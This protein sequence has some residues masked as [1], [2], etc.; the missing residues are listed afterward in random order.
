VPE[1]EPPDIVPARAPGRERSIA[2]WVAGSLLLHAGV[3]AFLLWPTLRGA[4]DALPPAAIEVELVAPSEAPSA[5]P[6]VPS[7]EAPSSEASAS[8]EP[9]SAEPP[10][11]QEQPSA[12]ASSE[13]PPET[14]SSAEPPPAPSEP[15]PESTTPVAPV[16]MSRPITVSVGATDAPSAEASSAEASGIT[17]LTAETG[18]VA[19]GDAAAADGS[20]SPAAEGELH[21]A[22]TF[23]LAEILGSA[24]MA[25][26]R[27][28]LET[29]PH[30]KR[31]SQ[32]CNIEAVGQVGSAGRG[33]TPDAVIAEAFSKAAISGTRL[34]ANGAIFRSA[35]KWYALAF[36][37][38]L[39]DDLSAVTA[40]TFRLGP[41]VTELVAK[42]QQA[43]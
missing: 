31:L 12:A 34:V 15:P 17:E 21:V 7:S 10:P 41:D 35:Q 3:L 39:N 33:F 43:N 11:S 29:L 9:S 28:A 13:P 26:A 38:T 32:T 24:S 2:G 40:F 22:E 20:D 25:R 23:Y 6:S 14:A 8:E 19:A 42:A 5:E 27:D 30:D 1:L 36:D 16:P 4:L 18:E 37:C